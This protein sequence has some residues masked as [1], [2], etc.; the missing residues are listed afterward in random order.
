MLR[1]PSVSLVYKVSTNYIRYDLPVVNGN[2]DFEKD[3][4]GKNVKDQIKLPDRIT[5]QKSLWNLINKEKAKTTIE[6]I[7]MHSTAVEPKLDPLNVI[8]EDT[9]SPKN[10]IFREIKHEEMIYPMEIVNGINRL[11]NDN[12]Q[13]PK[14]ITYLK[15]N[16]NEVKHLFYNLVTIATLAMERIERFDIGFQSSLKTTFIDNDEILELLSNEKNLQILVYLSVIGNLSSDQ[17]TGLRFKGLLNGI[18][19]S[20]TGR[21]FNKHPRNSLLVDLLLNIPPIL[22]QTQVNGNKKEDLLDEEDVGKRLNIYYNLSS[23]LNTILKVNKQYRRKDT[24]N[25]Y[26]ILSQEYNSKNLEQYKER[27]IELG[28][29]CKQANYKIDG[30]GVD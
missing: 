6:A 25:D 15:D 5:L 29:I 22:L 28:K 21:E 12:T 20:S 18:Q 7:I 16:A 24:I 19:V 9:N 14:I 8:K 11:I 23:H 1:S 30:G 27:L 17:Q 4:A 26:A 3:I 13:Q 10:P 2:I